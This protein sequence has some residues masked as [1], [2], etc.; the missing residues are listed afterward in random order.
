MRNRLTPF[1]LP[2][3]AIR[4]RI[5][6]SGPMSGLKENNA[7]AFSEATHSLRL[8][9]YAVCSPL[10]T[11]EWLGELTHAKYLRFDFAR[12]LEADFVVAL[13]GWEKSPGAR[14]EIF[15]ALNMDMLVWTHKGMF[16]LR[17]KDAAF[18][19]GWEAAP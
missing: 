19:I 15:M 6:L 18:A 4:A 2:L 16:N 9:G 5:Y 17:L 8:E 1:F 3:D 12:I 7:V 11:S 13:P 14:A 10:E